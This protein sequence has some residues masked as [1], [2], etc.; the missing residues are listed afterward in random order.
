[1]SETKFNIDRV[2]SKM[3][4]LKHELP[5]LLANQAQR[6]FTH[7]WQEQGMDGTPWKEVK[8]RIPGTPEYK[9]PKK[10][11]LTRRTKPILVQ[12]GHLRRAVADS[13][14]SQTWDRVT[15]VNAMPYA[16]FINEGTAKM[17]ARP[18]MKD[19]PALRAKQIELIN[20]TVGRIWQG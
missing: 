12:T 8:R 16:S 2:I 7:T 18:F 4:Q 1:M 13:I 11:G 10:K 14:K 9:Y 15:L 3:E 6:Y 17:V 19:T 20:K 5:V